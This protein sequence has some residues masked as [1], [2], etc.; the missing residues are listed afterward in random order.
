[1]LKKEAEEAAKLMKE[2]GIAGD[3]EDGEL[4]DIYTDLKKYGKCFNRINI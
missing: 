1:M 2:Y 4:A 3:D